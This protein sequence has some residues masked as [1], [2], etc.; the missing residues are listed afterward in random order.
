MPLVSTSR[1]LRTLVISTLILL[2]SYSLFIWTESSLSINV[3]PFGFQFDFDYRYAYA[4]EDDTIATLLQSQEE[5]DFLGLD[6]FSKRFTPAERL[7]ASGEGFC[8]NWTVPEDEEEIASREKESSCWKDDHYRQLK[9]FLDK[10]KTDKTYSE[11]SWHDQ[12]NARNMKSIRT[13]FGCLVYFGTREA[14][15]EECSDNMLNVMVLHDWWWD[16][17]LEGGSESGETVWLRAMVETFQGQ[18]YTMVSLN[19]HAYHYLVKVYNAL[20]DVV[21]FIYARDTLAISCLSDPRCR[22][23]FPPNTT[24]VTE[25]PVEQRRTIPS[26]KLFTVDYWGARP[27]DH[28]RSKHAYGLQWGEE[29]TFNPL[30][31]EW[32]ISP[33][34]Y[35]GHTHIPLTMEKSCLQLEVVSHGQ[36]K[37]EV[38]VLGKLFEYFYRTSFVPQDIWLSFENTTSLSPIANAHALKTDSEDD[39]PPGLVNKGPVAREDYYEQVANSKVFLGI[40]R[41]EI[42]PSP[43]LALCLGVPVVLPYFG[44]KAV[45]DG[46]DLYHSAAV[47][48][49]PAAS[50]RPPY[51]YSYH[52]DDNEN[53]YAAVQAARDNPIER[54]I[55]D[56]MRDANVRSE[57]LKLVTT[58]WHAR[59]REI[60]AARETR[61]EPA[62]VLVKQH[63][64][65]RLFHLGVGRRVGE[66]GELLKILPEKGSV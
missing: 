33:F 21:S 13:L 39:T 60:E 35:P 58:D 14:L 57:I 44:E 56:E 7:L 50:I 15:P 48:H 29:M 62:R 25:T 46:W 10:A 5:D 51:V 30:G 52:V 12:I 24:A 9:Y 1:L 16:L 27:G 64:I 19:W 3:K 53:M 43:Y 2:G 37:N 65:Q 34:P 32:T 8:E 17:A 54:Y 61:G 66:N 18:N 28:G 4:D 23:D 40:G 20:P 49:G 31:N 47:Q 63:I 55:P 45:P 36:R 42:S 11:L 38:T 6:D 41:P 22:S 59:S 26:W